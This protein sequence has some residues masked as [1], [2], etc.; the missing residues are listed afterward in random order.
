MLMNYDI[1]RSP[2]LQFKNRK[3][4]Y[5]VQNVEIIIYCKMYDYNTNQS[6]NYTTNDCGNGLISDISFS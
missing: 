2:T 4:S 3:I 6:G 5:I 1:T